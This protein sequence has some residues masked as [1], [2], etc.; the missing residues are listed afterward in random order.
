MKQIVKITELK[1]MT[2]DL[3]IDSFISVLMPL[4]IELY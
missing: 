3:K 2:E 1:Q 4:T